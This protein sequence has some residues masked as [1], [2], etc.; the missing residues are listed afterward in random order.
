MFMPI[1]SPHIS[2][3]PQNPIFR[4]YDFTNSRIYGKRRIGR[5]RFRVLKRRSY[6]PDPSGALR[7]PALS[8]RPGRK[9][10]PCSLSFDPL[11]L[12]LARTGVGERGLRASL[13]REDRLSAGQGRAPAQG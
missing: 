13:P 9:R 3:I 2:A 12:A 10:P 1:L 4:L 5:A 8:A 11:T 6:G 7:R